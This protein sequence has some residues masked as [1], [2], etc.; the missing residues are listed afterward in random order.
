[1][2]SR[3]SIDLAP[4]TKVEDGADCVAMFE[5]PAFWAGIELFGAECAGASVYLFFVFVKVFCAFAGKD[6]GGVAGAAVVEAAFVFD[7][8]SGTF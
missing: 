8:A 1:M 7:R 2:A 6:V 4:R 3:F 5:G